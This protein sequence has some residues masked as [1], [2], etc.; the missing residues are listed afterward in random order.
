MGTL[1]RIT[2]LAWTW[3]DICSDIWRQRW[4]ERSLDKGSRMWKGEWYWKEQKGKFM[5]DG[6]WIVG[7]CWLCRYW[8][9]PF[10]LWNHWGNPTKENTATNRDFKIPSQVSIQETTM[11]RKKLQNKNRCFD[12]RRE[13]FQ[14]RLVGWS[15]A[16]NSLWNERKWDLSTIRFKDR[17]TTGHLVKNHFSGLDG[18]EARWSWRNGSSCSAEKRDGVLAG[19]K[20]NI[21]WFYF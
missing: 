3:K 10:P 15:T 7:M 11:K 12:K 9:A 5:W 17:V 21:R 20:S 4:V 1:I 18:A 16:V 13:K 19:G 8:N 14:G 6:V 2:H